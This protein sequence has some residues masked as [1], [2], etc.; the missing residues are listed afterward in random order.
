M[1]INA[2]MYSVTPESKAAWRSIIDWVL[3]RAGVVACYEDHDPPALLSDLWRREDLACVMMCGLPFSM[4]NPTPAIL[5]TPVPSPARYGA[6]PVYWSDI[7]V[8]AG[9]D[10]RTLEETFG[11]RVGYTLKDSQSGYFALRYHLMRKFPSLAE[12][13][14]SITGNLLNPRG[15][16]K[17]LAEGRIDVGP[18]DSYVYDLLRHSDPEFASQVRIIESTDPTPMPPIV[19]TASL[20]MT[21]IERLRAA[22]LSVNTESTLESAREALLLDRFVVPDPSAYQVQRARAGEVERNC[23]PWP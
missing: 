1:L 18:L 12:P 9:S 5:A 23:R 7:A 14:P 17:A 2:R 16:I 6:S 10:F 4:R 11:C 19:S 15:I 3:R 20:P 8:H 22:F 21:T 13:Y